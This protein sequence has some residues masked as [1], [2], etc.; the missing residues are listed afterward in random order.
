MEH[1]SIRLRIQQFGLVAA[2]IA[3]YLTFRLLP[4]TFTGAEGDA[5]VFSEAGRKTLAV[6]VWMAIWWL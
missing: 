4:E 6:M 3:A 5:L 2:P 1:P